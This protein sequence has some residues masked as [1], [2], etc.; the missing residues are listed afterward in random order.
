MCLDQAFEPALGT[1]FH[2]E[3]IEGRDNNDEQA[4]K[5]RAVGEEDRRDK[6]PGNSQ[7]RELSPEQSAKRE[8]ALG[9]KVGVQY[10]SGA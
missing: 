10:F 6:S 2:R 1:P 7:G 4:V 3:G 5:E 8:G 9:F